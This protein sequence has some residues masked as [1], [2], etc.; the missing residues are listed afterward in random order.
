MTVESIMYAQS[1]RKDN[2][3]SKTTEKHQYEQTLRY[4]V[5]KHNITANLIHEI[6]MVETFQLF[7][8]LDEISSEYAY[9]LRIPW[10]IHLAGF[11][12]R[13]NAIHVNTMLPPALTND[14]DYLI[15]DE[16]HH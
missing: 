13:S 12:V 5:A 10:K 2:M 7:V 11:T 6:I 14:S 4:H 15:I 1:W 9:A 3:L 8:Q 16:I